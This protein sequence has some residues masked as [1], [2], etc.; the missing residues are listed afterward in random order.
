MGWLGAVISNGLVLVSK[1]S[2]SLGS[3]VTTN[4]KG[5]EKV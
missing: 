2:I 1:V 4:L 3:V 5:G